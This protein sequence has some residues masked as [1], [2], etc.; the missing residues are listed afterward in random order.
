MVRLLFGI[1]ILFITGCGLKNSFFSNEI[2][3]ESLL[4]NTKKI[5]I[6]NS[7]LLITYLNNSLDNFKDSKKENFLINLYVDDN[8]KENFD[9]SKDISISGG[10]KPIKVT[11]LSQD[12]ELLK[13]VPM[14]SKWSKYYLVEFDK[15]DKNRINLIFNDKNGSFEYLFFFKDY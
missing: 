4:S 6:S 3:K 13:I 12:S 7:T 2:V 1:F 10:I 9:I 5:T 11:K 15:V 8:E 14:G